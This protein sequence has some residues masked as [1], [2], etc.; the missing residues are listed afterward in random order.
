MI[1]SDNV[2]AVAMIGALGLVA[3]VGW[4]LY[5]TG[6]SA[7]E[8]VSETLGDISDGVGSIWHEWKGRMAEVVNAIKPGEVGPSGGGSRQ[9][10][11]TMPDDPLDV[12]GYKYGEDPDPSSAAPYI[13]ALADTQDAA[14]TWG[15]VDPSLGGDNALAWNGQPQ[16]YAPDA[17][18]LS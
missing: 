1:S 12:P 14:Y 13:G 3:F 7:A 18:G 11:Q 15:S 17:M 9:E 10:L 4:K 5:R 6:A 2:K 8:S 16:R